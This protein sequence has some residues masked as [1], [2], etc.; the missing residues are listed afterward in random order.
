MGMHMPSTAEQY[1]RVALSCC[2]ILS[3]TLTFYYMLMLFV[4]EA[5]KV[6]LQKWASEDIMFNESEQEPKA[7]LESHW[8]Y[9]YVWS[10][11][12]D[13]DYVGLRASFLRNVPADAEIQAALDKE[14]RVFSPH[15]FPFW[16]YV[17][18]CVNS[19]THVLYSFRVPERLIIV[20]SFAAIALLH[21]VFAI[22]FVHILAVFSAVGLPLL[23]SMQVVITRRNRDACSSESLEKTYAAAKTSTVVD[24]TLR[25]ISFLLF[26]LCYGVARMVCQRSM[27]RLHFH[28][29][30]AVT[31]IAA[32]T[33]GIFILHV[34]QMIPKF[35]LGM[36]SPPY[37]NEKHVLR[38]V[39]LAE[40]EA[41]LTA[42]SSTL[43]AG[44]GSGAAFTRT[45][46]FV[47]APLP[48]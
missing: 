5:T 34:A 45:S 43:S 24:A 22:S 44:R 1:R 17:R 19:H 12:E 39:A 20:L 38:T 21:F 8:L 29:T 2:V 35:V 6:M 42:R 27:W 7:A 40:Q 14:G 28:A 31:I 16:K 32:V 9:H 25:A 30:L 33:T 10:R 23:L 48:E 13:L 46:A 4:A 47:P 15:N 18:L 11:A 36:S 37:I 41:R 3:F 26:F